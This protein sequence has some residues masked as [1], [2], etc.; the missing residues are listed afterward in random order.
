M[1]KEAM[2]P[3]HPAEDEEKDEFGSFPRPSPSSCMKRELHQ[4]LSGYQVFYYTACSLLVILHN[5]CSK[6]HNQKG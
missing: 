5:S 3:D 4:N 2:R 1:I 6:L